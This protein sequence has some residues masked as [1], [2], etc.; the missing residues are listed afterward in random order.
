MRGATFPLLLYPFIEGTETTL[1]SVNTVG[2]RLAFHTSKNNDIIASMQ[3]T[4][5]KF[6]ITVL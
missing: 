6:K 1:P 3:Q 5:E 2:Q 4:I